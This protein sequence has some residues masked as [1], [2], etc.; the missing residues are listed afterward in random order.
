MELRVDPAKLFWMVWPIYALIGI[1]FAIQ[2]ERWLEG[3]VSVWSA[4]GLPLLLPLMGWLTRDRWKLEIT[5]DA[6]L[7]HTLLKTERYEWRRMGPVE[8]HWQHV[9]HVPLMKTLWFR[10]PTDTPHGVTEQ[11]TSRIGRRL[12]PIFGDRSLRETAELLESWRKLAQA[13]GPMT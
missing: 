4:I 13:S 11:I 6:L 12:L 5:A 10:F 9:I 2:P 8:T 1:S 7:H 3:G